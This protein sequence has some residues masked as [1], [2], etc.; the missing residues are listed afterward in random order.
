MFLIA[1]ILSPICFFILLFN[2]GVCTATCK[3]YCAPAKLS[4]SLRVKCIRKSKIFHELIKLISLIS[5]SCLSI[6]AQLVLTN[7]GHTVSQSSGIAPLMSAMDFCCFKDNATKLTAN[8][9]FKVP[10]IA[11]KKDRPI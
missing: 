10:K 5:R 7:V 1:D 3:I 8:V 11:L 6:L 4:T 2:R 9:L